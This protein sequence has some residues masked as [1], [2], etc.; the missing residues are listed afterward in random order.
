[1]MGALVTGRIAKKIKLKTIM[2]G[3]LILVTVGTVLVGPSALFILPDEI[4]IIFVGFT[5]LGLAAAFCYVPVT[6]EII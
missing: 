5:L 4:W 6:P 2:M 1:M 3:G